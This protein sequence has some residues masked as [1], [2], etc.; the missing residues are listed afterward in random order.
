MWFVFCCPGTEESSSAYITI[1][2][3][4]YWMNSQKKFIL[5]ES[6]KMVCCYCASCHN[7]E[8]ARISAETIAA[9]CSSGAKR[10]A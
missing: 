5:E 8:I 3:G 10:E 7:S 9:A 6:T 1:G 2:G 4:E